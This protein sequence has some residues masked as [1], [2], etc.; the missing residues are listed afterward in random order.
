MLVAQLAAVA[1]A[2][3]SFWS[4]AATIRSTLSHV[5]RA[6][7]LARLSSGVARPPAH[8]WVGE[9]GAPG[10]TAPGSYCQLALPHSDAFSLGPLS[11]GSVAPRPRGECGIRQSC[12]DH[13]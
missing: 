8:A 10:V 1:M 11:H 2:T 12:A 13:V 6:A 7:P 9:H 5:R 4:R 3:A